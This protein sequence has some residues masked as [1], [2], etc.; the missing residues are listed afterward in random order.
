MSFQPTGFQPTGFQTG[1][2][3]Q[4][5]GGA[6]PYHRRRLNDDDECMLLVSMCFMEVLNGGCKEETGGKA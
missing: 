2:Q 3:V 6:N 1:Q 4:T 5:G